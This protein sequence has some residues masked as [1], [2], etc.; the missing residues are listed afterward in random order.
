MIN[1]LLTGT[2]FNQQYTDKKFVKLTNQLENHNQYQFQ[3]G[4][5]IDSLPF[6]P[7]GQCQPGGIYFCQL[8][9]LHLWLNYANL[10]MFY[11]RFV[12]IPDDALVWTEVGERSSPITPFLSEL[13]S[14]KFKTNCLIL[15]NR[16][17]IGDLEIWKD[18]AYCLTAV[19]YDGFSLRYIKQQTKEINLAAVE[20]D[21][22]ALQYVRNQTEEIC[23]E[24][25]Q[26]YGL[27]LKYVKQQTEEICLAAVKKDALALQ[28]VSEQTPQICL[29]AVRQDGCALKYVTEQ[30]LQICLIAVHNSDYAHIY[31]KDEGAIRYFK[32]NLLSY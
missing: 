20:Q 6:N 26:N 24:A 15:G 32:E 21:G 11:V 31:V 18:P 30:S 28:Y 27:T 13:F 25:V 12:T 14:K 1:Q 3:T 5:N 23:L 19:K 2:I 22:Y 9:D 8:E 4:L 10:E 29:A 16:M 17:E 7:H